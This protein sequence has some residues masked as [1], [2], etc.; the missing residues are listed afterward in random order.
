[1]ICCSRRP[2]RVISACLPTGAV[3]SPRRYHRRFIELWSGEEPEL[4]PHRA[5]AERRM[6]RLNTSR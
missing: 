1:M 4:Q 6:A 3:T 2:Q 5:E